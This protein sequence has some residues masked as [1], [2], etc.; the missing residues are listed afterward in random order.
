MSFAGIACICHLLSTCL[1]VHR[2]IHPS[3]HVSVRAS[4][5][6]SACSLPVCLSVYLRLGGRRRLGAVRATAG[7]TGT[8]GAAGAARCMAHTVQCNAH[9]TCTASPPHAHHISP[10]LHRTRTALAPHAYCICT[11]HAHRMRSASAPHALRM[12]TACP[13]RAG[14][15]SFVLTPPAGTALVFGG[16]VTHAARAARPC[17]KRR[18]GSA[19][20]PPL[21]TVGS[22][23]A[24]RAWHSGRSRRDAQRQRSAW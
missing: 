12:R 17:R 9:C 3:A 20:A 13:P 21:P 5:C 8:A 10:Y 1:S 15:P 24:L 23:Q 18:L 6:L 7:P 11:A 16:S 4:I 22:Y 19:T 2:A 14:P